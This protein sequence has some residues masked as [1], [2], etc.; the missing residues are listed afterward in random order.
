MTQTYADVD[1]SANPTE[2]LKWQERIDAWP[3]IQA[4]KRAARTQ[5]RGAR[6]V[7]DVG[8]GPGEDVA[9]IS[10]TE[11]VALDS[12]WIM[13]ERA[14]TRI[15]RVVLG[16]AHALPFGE[17]VFEG[18]RADRVLQ[19]LADPQVALLEMVR[20]TRA[21]GRVVIADPDQETLS[22]HVPGVPAQVTHR[23]KELRRDLGYRNGTLARELP[24]RFASLGLRDI[25]VDATTLVLTDPDDAFGLPTWPR[26]WQEEGGFSDDEIVAWDQAMDR[27]RRDGMVYAVTYLVVSGTRPGM[28][29]WI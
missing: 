17:E 12:S 18:V 3:A 15:E 22:I 20:V 1:G 26:R 16:D 19:H 27:A 23:L 28:R 14:A 10:R 2:A 4:Y 6:R 24:D 29:S 8:C 9:S 21:N 13:C 5:L 7:L 25:A 11:A